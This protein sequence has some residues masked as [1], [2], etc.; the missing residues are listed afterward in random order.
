MQETKEK[1]IK[2]KINKISVEMI[3]KAIQDALSFIEDDDLKIVFESEFSYRRNQYGEE[4]IHFSTKIGSK[5][6]PKNDDNTGSI[7][8]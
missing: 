5:P 8:W 6:K 1:D 4:K 3:E 2:E 7:G